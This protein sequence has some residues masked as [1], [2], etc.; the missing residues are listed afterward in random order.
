MVLVNKC[1]LAKSTGQVVS[2]LPTHTHGRPGMVPCGDIQTNYVKS[3]ILTEQ[4]GETTVVKGRRE[5]DAHSTR[6]SIKG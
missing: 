2:M 5:R 1:L 4:S 6:P 3:R